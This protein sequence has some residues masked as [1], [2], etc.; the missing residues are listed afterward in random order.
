LASDFAAIIRRFGSPLWA[1]EIDE[2]MAER[3]SLAERLAQDRELN[4]APVKL[5]SGKKLRFSAGEHNKLQ[6]EK[7]NDRI[8][9]AHSTRRRAL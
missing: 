9:P 4:T 2:L 7:M 3:E 6:K 5:P 8:R 1:D